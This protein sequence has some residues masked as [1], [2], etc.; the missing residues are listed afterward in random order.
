MGSHP[1]VALGWGGLE[2]LNGSA[3][4][5]KL[6]AGLEAAEVPGFQCLPGELLSLVCASVYPSV[7]WG[8]VR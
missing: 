5:E 6:H 2:K 4:G 8:W 3:P 7:K 1:Q